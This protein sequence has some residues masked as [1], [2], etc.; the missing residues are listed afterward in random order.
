MTPNA[1]SG[2]AVPREGYL[3]V[4]NARLYYRQIG[5]GRPIIVLH[6]GPDFSHSYLLPE[7]DC[8]A[9][10]FQL[11]YYD[12]RG[13]GRSGDGVR[14]EDVGIESEM[15]DLEELRKFLHLETVA[16]LG[17]S[18]G[19]LL[20]MEYAI[21]HPQRLSRL[22]LMNTA[23]ASH[24][25]LVSFRET[26]R[27][28]V[29]GDL[30]EMAALAATDGYRS[31]DL[32]TDAAYYRIHFRSTLRHPDQLEKVVQRLRSHLTPEGIRRARAIEDRLYE[33]TW[34][35]SEYDLLPKLGRLSIPALVI[36]G[37][38]DFIPVPCAEHIARAIPDARLILLKDCGH[39]SYLERPVEVQTALTE[40]LE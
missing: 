30:E 8:L 37:E 4:P 27:R 20:A 31:G 35:S 9:E 38:H 5:Q 14:P 1:S 32:E 11:I 39:F 2:K 13:R 23:P 40:F 15:A 26:R 16:V 12:Q 19:G 10:S 21:R 36:H 18:W 24:G 7:M 28:A 22:I 29:A 33:Q 3:P 6:G 34:N 17:H 25:D